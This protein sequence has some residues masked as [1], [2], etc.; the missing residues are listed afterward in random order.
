MTKSKH[1]NN[2]YTSSGSA[3]H[4]A[5]HKYTHHSN[6][7]RRV[8]KVLKKGFGKTA[9]AV[10]I[11]LMLLSALPLTGF[12]KGNGNLSPFTTSQFVMQN[13]IWNRV[14]SKFSFP[15]N[16]GQSSDANARIQ[17]FLRQ[18]DHNASAVQKFAK[19]SHYIYYIMD[20]LEKRDMPGELALLPMLESSYQPTATSPTGA[21]G[22]WQ[23]T[24]G[25]G[26]VF[27]LKQ[28]GLYDGRR[29]IRASTK[30]ALDYLEYLHKMF[31][32]DWMLALAAYNAG[33]GTVGKA[34]SAKRSE[35]GPI[36]FW[37]LSL[38]KETQDY[39]PKLLAMAEIVEHPDLHRVSL[40]QIEDRP[41]FVEVDPHKALPLKQVAKLA[42]L[43][44]KE[45]K[46]LNAAYKNDSTI[47]NGPQHL[48]LPQDNATKFL[49]NL[50][51]ESLT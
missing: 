46:S 49:L 19:A 41:Y 32:G 42:G 28:D 34:I 37:S 9:K 5:A 18:Y 6:L 14:R 8:S 25:T 26:R 21:A 40:P 13:Q 3:N 20:E 48:L 51:K 45:V 11:G 4:T 29:D 38:P 43:D 39:V 10:L 31:H 17:T 16:W 12:T 30:A 27:H 44:V 7:E 2:A 33:E 22:L 15:R 35:G 36:S 50:V 24:R 1:S 23:F 47:P